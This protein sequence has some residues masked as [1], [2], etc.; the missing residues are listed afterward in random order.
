MATTPGAQVGKW[1]VEYSNGDGGAAVKTF[2][3][4][5]VL[6]DHWTLVLDPDSRAVKFASPNVKVS[7]VEPVN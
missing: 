3:G 6:Q 7:N 2:S 5:L 1:R 4:K